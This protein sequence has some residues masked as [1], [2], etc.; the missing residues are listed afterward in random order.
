VLYFLRVQIE[1]NVCNLDVDSS[2]P[3]GAEAAKGPTV[4]R[5]KRYA[6]WVQNGVSQFGFYLLDQKKD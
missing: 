1:E 3:S 4:R 5:L 6:S 2:Y